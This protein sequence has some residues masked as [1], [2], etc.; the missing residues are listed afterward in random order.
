M[1]CFWF[2]FKSYVILRRFVIVIIMHGIL[3][4]RIS[5]YCLLVFCFL[6]T[7]MLMYEELLADSNKIYYFHVIGDAMLLSLPVLF[8][9]KKLVIC[10]YLAMI[11]LYI[12][13]IVWYYRVYYTLMPLS[14]YL[15]I[16][17]LKGIGS[18]ICHSVHYSDLK[19]ITPVLLFSIYYWWIFHVGGWL[20]F[21]SLKKRCIIVSIIFL[22]SVCIISAPYWPNQRPFYKQP[23]YLYKYTSITAIKKY[24]IVNYW[25][26]QYISWQKVSNKDKLYAHKFVEQLSERTDIKMRD[27]IIHKNLILL[28]VE[29]LQSWP[30]GLRVGTKEVTP[31]INSLIKDTMTVYFPKVMPQVKDGR[32]SDAQLLINTGLLPLASGA[33]SSLCSMNTFPSLAYAFK[34]KRY[35]SMSFVCDDKTFWNQGATTVAYGFDYLFDCLQGNKERKEAD[36]NLFRES[37]LL[38]TELKQPFYAQLVTLSSHGP[39]VVPI[40]T[41]SFLL[42]ENFENDEV[43]NYLIAVQYVDKCIAEFIE[44]LKEDGLY[45]NSIIVITGDH[46]QMTYNNYEGREKVKAEDCFVPF[47]II[48]SPLFSKHTSK[49]FGQVDIYPSLLDIMGCTDYSW[50]GLGESVFGDIVSDYAAFRTGISIG[51]TNVPDSVKEHR[52]ECW[53]VSDI[54]LRMNYFK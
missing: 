36:G 39:Y 2:C 25:I 19:L 44:G 54:L 32:S 27:S 23:L 11:V 28:L 41:E 42:N 31:Y 5:V 16:D 22:L 17:N 3:F 52:N 7:V 48:N 51:G 40:M 8:C 14:S 15:L 33:A 10:S 46:E 30:I 1:P 34:D 4:K 49:V 12:L 18:S 37:L 38:L 6:L 24:G 13:S 9:K 26:F 47:I 53:R 45:D 35:V 50:R 29:S 20:A 21:D 43:R